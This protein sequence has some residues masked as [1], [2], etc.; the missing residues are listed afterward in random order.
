M[1]NA[2]HSQPMPEMTGA[3]MMHEPLHQGAFFLAP[4]KIH[5]V[6]AVFSDSCGFRVFFY[7]AFT[8]PIHSDRFQAFAHVFPSKED[9]IDNIRFLSPSNDNTM[10][11]TA[12]G[13]WVSRPFKVS[14][15][16]KFPES[17]EPQIFTILVPEAEAHGG[18]NSL[19]VVQCLEPRPQICTREYIPVCASLMDG[20][21][22]TYPSGCTACSDANVVS[23]RPDQCE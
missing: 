13:D 3:H 18:E 15:Y 16:V 4:D 14:L 20:A 22:K 19:D 11:A 12:F 8:E 10:L 21:M 1:Q 23:Y 7:N 17:D 6:E 2:G 5:H 9:E